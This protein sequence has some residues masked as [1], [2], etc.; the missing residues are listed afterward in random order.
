[1]H[2]CLQTQ[3]QAATVPL[4]LQKWYVGQEPAVVAV[5]VAALRLYLLSLRRRRGAL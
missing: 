2:S 5:G 4:A 1:M 3:C